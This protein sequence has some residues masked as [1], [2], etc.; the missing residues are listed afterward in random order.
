ML[1][2]SRAKKD[3]FPKLWCGYSGRGQS[4]HIRFRGSSGHSETHR[5]DR[6]HPPK[7]NLNN[8]TGRHSH[9]CLSNSS[10]SFKC[11]C[12]FDRSGESGRGITFHGRREAR[13]QLRILKTLKDGDEESGLDNSS[14]LPLPASIFEKELR[15]GFDAWLHLAFSP[16]EMPGGGRS[17]VLC[18]RD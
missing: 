10:S 16:T 13:A 12:R 2:Q 3:P 17:P 4:G 6:S 5:V 14:S 18:T 9:D 1:K 11:T 15:E 8:K 7:K